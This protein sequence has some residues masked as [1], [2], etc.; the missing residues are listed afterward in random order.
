[1]A[2]GLPSLLDGKPCVLKGEGMKRRPFVTALL[3]ASALPVRA[4]ASVPDRRLGLVIASY[5]HR[6]K[7]K[8]S[9]VRIP[10]FKDALDV[11]DHIRS[12]DFGCLQTGVEGWTLDLA[13]QIRQTCESY[14]MAVEGSVKLPVAE[15]DVSRFEREL[16]T[17]REAGVTLFRSAMGGRRYEV[18]T[19][20]ADFESW[21]T[22]ALKS[23]TLAEPVL[24]KLQA[25]VGIENH[26]DWQVAEL[27][28]ALK[29]LSSEHVGACVDTGN[30]L[31]LLEDPL[32]AV[33]ALAPYAVTVHLKDIAVRSDS[34]GFSMSEV[35]LGQ[36]SLDLP[37]VITTLT[38]AR[39]DVRLNLEMITRDPLEIPCL[40]ERYWATFPDKPGLDLARSLSWVRQHENSALPRVSHLSS[41]ALLTLEEENLRQCLRYASEKLGFKP[42]PLPANPSSSGH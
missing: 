34:R 8:Y 35:P 6:W 15:A 1:M 9:N 33:Q 21:K 7:G 18:F 30:S 13:K 26:K 25:K 42:S 22:A 39:P 11:L 36:G 10:P 17:A 5:S 20:Q 24:R 40:E 29:A 14:D 23:M 16:R 31:A 38:S 41:P 19:R 4:A 37:Q 2:R 32:A 3:A 12:L 28:S 27:L